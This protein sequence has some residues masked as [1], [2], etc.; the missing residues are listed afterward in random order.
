MMI[1]IVGDMMMIMIEE[2]ITIIDDMIT[3]GTMMI[4]GSMM[5]GDIMITEG[6]TEVIDGVVEVEAVSALLGG[7]LV[8]KYKVIYIMT[9]T[10]KKTIF[11][12]T[13]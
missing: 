7:V 11:L 5:T 6:S 9:H 2:G 4:E 8:D 1:I 13:H 12:F 10:K 3:D